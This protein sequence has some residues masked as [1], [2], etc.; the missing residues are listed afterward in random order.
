MKIATLA[1]TMALAVASNSLAQT[2]AAAPAA[3]PRTVRTYRLTYATSQAEQNEILT[4]IRN[5]ATPNLRIFLLQTNNEIAAYG[6]AED[7]AQVAD[8]LPKLD[9]PHK[10]Y[11]VTYTFTETDGGK[12][13]GLQH[14]SMVVELGQRVMMKEGSRVPLV[15]S[16]TDKVAQRTYLDVGLTFD[17]TL[18]EHGAGFQLKSR[19]EQTSIA[20]E[21]S[22]F[23]LEDPV[24]RQTYV[25]GTSVLPEG[26]AVS[27]GAL[28]VLGSTRHLDVEVLVEPVR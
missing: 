24:I 12:R 27:L 2:S 21:K 16:T 28:D 17:S 7:L 3:A 26:S 25:E 8:L 1:V 5:I 9:L 14:Y 23:G 19:V 10:Q 15:T 11:R 18:Q 20:E 22:G 6:T 13:V 4:A